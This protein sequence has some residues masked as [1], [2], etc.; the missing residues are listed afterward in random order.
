MQAK[1]LLEAEAQA[2]AEARRREAKEKDVRREGKGGTPGD[3]E[4]AP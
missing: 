3:G 1:A 2:G 4:P